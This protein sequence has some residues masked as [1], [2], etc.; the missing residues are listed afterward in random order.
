MN[1]EQA[2]SITSTAPWNPFDSE[3]EQRAFLFFQDQTTPQLAEFH[4][5]ELWT[6]VILQAVHADSGTRH[7]VIALALLHEQFQQ[8][9]EP[10]IGASDAVAKHYSLA[11]QSHLEN[12]AHGKQRAGNVEF[13]LISCILFFCIETLQGHSASALSL[14]RRAVSLLQELHQNA[15]R[16]SAWSLEV[17]ENLLCRLQAQ[18][19]GLVGPRAFPTTVPPRI[20]AASIPDMPDRF[21]SIDQAKEYLE[22]YR[23]SHDLTQS[24]NELSDLHSQ[25]PRIILQYRDTI[26]QWSAAFNALQR[27]LHKDSLSYQN[28]RALI[29]LTIHQRFLI[30]S[31]EIAVKYP[32][33]T[34]DE[35]LWD[36]FHQIYSEVVDLAESVMRLPL[37]DASGADRLSYEKPVFTLDFG[38]IVPLYDVVRQCRDPGIRSRAIALL[39]KHPRREGFL[40]SSFVAHVLERIVE[41]EHGA[42]QRNVTV[43]SDVPASARIC[44]VVPTFNMAEQAMEVSYYRRSDPT[45][46]Q[47]SLVFREFVK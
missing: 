13:Y 30:L 12:L 8:T 14:L 34:T 25:S 16:Q 47:A 39:R 15:Q 45:Q 37:S 6:H 9:G 26:L 41:L 43:A 1:A 10:R 42:A 46:A 24:T 36:H 4:G 38:I 11:I 5:C 28:R 18:A 19:I 32:Q 17:F 33:I 35:S 27:A 44:F 20:K 22:Y 7:A 29:M 40:D 3:N 21:A 2:L 31:M 23:Q